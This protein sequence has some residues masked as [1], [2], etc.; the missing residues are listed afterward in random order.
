MNELQIALAL[1]GVLA[2]IGIL[3][4]NRFQERRFRRQTE[5]GF[6]RPGRDVLFDDETGAAG[7]AQPGSDFQDPIAGNAGTGLFHGRDG[8]EPHFGDTEML[9]DAVLDEYPVQSPAALADEPSAYS[10][11]PSQL[12]AVAATHEESIEFCVAL[13]NLQ[14]MPADL[15]D[16]VQ[17]RSAELAK[18]VRWLALP[19]GSPAWEDLSAQSGKRYLEVRVIAPLADRDG[20]IEKDD[21]SALCEMVQKLAL[22]HDWQIRCD[23]PAEAAAKAQ[24]LDKFC[25]DVDVQIGLNI[26]ARGTATLPVARVRREAEHA[27][28]KLARNGVY[29]LLDSRGEVLFMLASREAQPF[30]LDDPHEPETRGVTLLFD[31]PRVPDGLKNFDSMVTLGR[32]LAHEGSG[33]LVDDNLRPLTDIGIEKIRAQL[34]QIYVRMEARGVPAGS[35]VALRLFS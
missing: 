21:L 29:Q 23:D 4:Y 17:S 31:V 8:N 9:L 27:G 13:K 30:S 7:A 18:P 34:A 26:V 35:R 1:I 32:K 2:V 15:F 10:P 28:M 6:A 19:L 25:A 14:G 33:L 11:S 22:E 16:Y 20:A 12:Q 5:A 3:I 24:S